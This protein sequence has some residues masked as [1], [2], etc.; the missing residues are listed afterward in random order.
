[1]SSKKYMKQI[2]NIESVLW[3]MY[4]NP[5]RFTVVSESIP[6]FLPTFLQCLKPK[7]LLSCFTSFSKLQRTVPQG[8]YTRQYKDA[9]M[10]PGLC[11]SQRNRL[12]MF[13]L[14][15]WIATSDVLY[16]YVRSDTQWE[17]IPILARSQTPKSD[18]YRDTCLQK[19]KIYTTLLYTWFEYHLYRSFLTKWALQKVFIYNAF[20]Y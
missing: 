12:L 10:L 16:I 2:Q 4:G 9:N 8:F 11:V 18:K 3:I 14:E 6:G 19:I 1:M 7:S 20:G 15:W 5:S 13:R 17:W